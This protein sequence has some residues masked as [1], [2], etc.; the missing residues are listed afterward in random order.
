MLFYNALGLT[1]TEQ[2]DHGQKVPYIEKGKDA[3]IA[4]GSLDFQFKNET[5]NPIKIYASTD[6]NNVT[7]RIV[8]LG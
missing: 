5:T 6:G 4:Y 3:T 1:V 7:V 2:H 8:S